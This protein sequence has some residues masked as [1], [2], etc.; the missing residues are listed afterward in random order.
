VPIIN[1]ERRIVMAE[2]AAK[3]AK[4]GEQ[5]ASVPVKKASAESPS[6]LALREAAVE[7]LF[8]DLFDDFERGFRL[9]RLFRR[10]QSTFEAPKLASVDVY[11][12]EGE[13]V[14]KAEVPG[15]VK[16]EIE[17]T[18]S[19]SMLTLKGEKKRE[20]EEKR[21]NYHRTERSFGSVQRVIELPSEVKADKATAKLTDGVLE[22]HL[23]KTEEAKSKSVKVK[24]E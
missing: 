13:V 5:G 8:E 16:D 21:E 9:P 2:T 6:W 17:I 15:M 12:T 3:P 7:R 24:V 18:A 4:T 10:L 19:G 1:R 23:P 11:E 22:I 14:V 20:E